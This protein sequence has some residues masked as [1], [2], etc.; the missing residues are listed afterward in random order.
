MPG[1]RG[2][3]VLAP[4]RF[5]LIFHRYYP[6]GLFSQLYLQFPRN[7]ICLFNHPDLGSLN[8]ADLSWSPKLLV[9]K[10]LSRVSE[11]SLPSCP[12]SLFPASSLHLT[13]LLASLASPSFP[14]FDLPLTSESFSVAD[15]V[16]ELCLFR[17]SSSGSP[18]SW[19]AQRLLNT[20][21]GKNLPEF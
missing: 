14:A 20:S 10:S 1:L 18:E 21:G 5:H 7:S 15:L 4:P 3:L 6:S 16:L 11:P 13:W 9:Y 12:S 8:H 2:L 19:Q 17:V